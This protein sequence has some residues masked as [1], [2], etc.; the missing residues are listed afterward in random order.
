ME[1][2]KLELHLVASA[3]S[4][5]TALTQEITQWWTEMLEGNPE[6]ENGTF[7][8]RFGDAVFKT[9]E[10]TT[11][12]PNERVVWTVV[13]SLIDLP[14]LVNK[15]EWIG[16]TII[17][18]I[19]PTDT[20]TSLKLTHIGLTPEIECFAIC[21]EGWKQFTDSLTDHIHD[22]KGKPFRR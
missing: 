16:T 3:E 18:D 2:H 20:G 11:L 9:I 15:T 10:V 14:A 13:D 6:A 19:V 7:T 17:W 8:V 12:I 22:R 4:V 1:N 5:Y 21:R